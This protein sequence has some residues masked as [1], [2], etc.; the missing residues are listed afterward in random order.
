MR[1]HRYHFATQMAILEHDRFGVHRRE[2]NGTRLHNDIL[3]RDFAQWLSHSALQDNSR[4]VRLVASHVLDM[5]VSY[6]GKMG[7]V[8]TLAPIHR[9]DEEE[10]L[11]L[12]KLAVLEIDVANEAASVRVGLHVERTLA[13]PARCAVLDKDILHACTHF[14]TDDHAVQALESAIANNDVLR[15]HWSIQPR[16]LLANVPAVIVASSLDGHIVDAVVPVFAVL[17]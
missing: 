12:V 13:I 17:F 6:I 15:G 10:V 2:A 11:H 5:D 9:S 14:A 4:I 7:V 3:K 8:R 16:L 1:G